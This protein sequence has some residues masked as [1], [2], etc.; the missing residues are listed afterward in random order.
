MTM[1]IIMI[2]NELFIIML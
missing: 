1:M 2:L